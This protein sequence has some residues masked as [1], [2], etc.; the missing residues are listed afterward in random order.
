MLEKSVA[1]GMMAKVSRSAPIERRTLRWG[2]SMEAE[3]G[4][5]RVSARLPIC[6][7]MHRIGMDLPAKDQSQM[8][9]QVA[10]EAGRKEIFF[11]R[12]DWL[13]TF[14]DKWGLICVTRGH[15]DPSSLRWTPI[16]SVWPGKGCTAQH[17][18]DYGRKTSATASSKQKPNFIGSYGI[19]AR[20]VA[21]CW[22]K[23]ILIKKAN[24]SIWADESLIASLGRPY[25]CQLSLVLPE[26]GW[27]SD[28][29]RWMICLAKPL[30]YP[31]HSILYPLLPFFVQEKVQ[32]IRM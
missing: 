22:N 19:S 26:K 25:L 23:F 27:I 7:T 2:G 31:S 30:P 14:G 10:Q 1:P 9:R 4:L 20:A 8:I 5:F 17:K 16:P 21:C 6:S 28:D 3:G 24:P 18:A 15:Q 12:W 13:V 32:A 11:R 29:S